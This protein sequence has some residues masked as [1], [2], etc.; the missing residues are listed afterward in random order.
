M[1]DVSQ[2]INIPECFTNCLHNRDVRSWVDDL[3]AELE[4]RNPKFLTPRE[5]PTDDCCE[6]AESILDCLYNLDDE[7]ELNYFKYDTPSG[8]TVHGII[9]K[10]YQFKFSTQ[11]WCQNRHN[12][13]SLEEKMSAWE[14][15]AA[16]PVW[17]SQGGEDR[18]TVPEL[19]KIQEDILIPHTMTQS[20]H[21][22]PRL[23][24]SPHL[25]CALTTPLYLP[26]L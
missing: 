24:E 7:E 9:E 2:E 20:L 14:S 5:K 16:G 26:V 1:C 18:R 23:A 15:K 12:T 17:R 13:V 22:T 8:P 21:I 10:R 4:K 6:H 19:R 11:T 3:G 25:Q